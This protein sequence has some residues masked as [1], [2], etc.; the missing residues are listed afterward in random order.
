MNR[1]VIKYKSEFAKC[2]QGALEAKWKIHQQIILRYELLSLL[3]K[4][5]KKKKQLI[6]ECFLLAQFKRKRTKRRKKSTG[7]LVRCYLSF[8]CHFYFFL[9]FIYV[10]IWTSFHYAYFL[11][12]N[13][14][15]NILPSLALCH[16]DT[17]PLASSR[18]FAKQIWEIKLKWI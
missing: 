2:V 4:E 6:K 14:H 18:D 11:C 17:A 9:V 8:V 15:H 13:K 16:N 7:I 1:Q 5:R 12:L 10:Q 3:L